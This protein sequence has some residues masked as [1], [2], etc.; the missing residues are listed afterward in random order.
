MKRFKKKCLHIVLQIK[1]IFHTFQTKTD[2]SYP[3]NLLYFTVEGNPI[4]TRGKTKH[5]PREKR[6]NGEGDKTFNLGKEFRNDTVKF[7]N[8]YVVFMTEKQYISGKKTYDWYDTKTNNI[9]LLPAK[10]IPDVSIIKLHPLV[11]QD[12]VHLL[13]RCTADHIVVFLWKATRV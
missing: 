4:A 2:L 1:N 6:V 9:D 12:T 13:P 10:C 3:E 5:L 11:A 8:T 7:R